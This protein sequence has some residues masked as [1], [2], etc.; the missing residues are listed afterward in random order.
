MDEEL[1]SFVLR[2][3]NEQNEELLSEAT[4]RI[5]EIKDSENAFQIVVENL[6]NP[7]F[8][9]QQRNCCLLILLSYNV[10][11]ADP[12]CLFPLLLGQTDEFFS[13]LSKFIAKN[14]T[15]E[16]KIDEQ[17]CEIEELSL[18]K[19][20]YIL[21]DIYLN[22]N[23]SE[24]EIESPLVLSKLIQ[25]SSQESEDINSKIIAAKL[26]SQ[27]SGE[28][29]EELV[30]FLTAFL[31][32]DVE[33]EELIPLFCFL[34]EKLCDVPSFDGQ[35]ELFINLIEKISNYS[36]LESKIAKEVASFLAIFQ[37]DVFENSHEEYDEEKLLNSLLS[38]SIISNEQYEELSQDI[39]SFLMFYD[40][41]T[42]LRYVCLQMIL[43]FEE[44]RQNA[45]SIIQQRWGTDPN[46]QDMCY[47]I[48][49]NIIGS[50]D[51][52]FEIDIIEPFDN[53]FCR[54][55]YVCTLMANRSDCNDLIE[56]LLS[57]EDNFVEPLYIAN[58][59]LVSDEKYHHFLPLCVSRIISFINPEDDFSFD[60]LLS[61]MNLLISE[62]PSVFTDC[63]EELKT[64]LLTMLE[65]VLGHA[66]LT[67]EICDIFAQ[68]AKNEA[69]HHDLMETLPQIIIDLLNE[70]HFDVSF[71]LIYS[72]FHNMQEMNEISHQI[73]EA[74]NEFIPTLPITN[75]SC[76]EL[77]GIA[78]FFVRCNCLEPFIPW[79]LEA[80]NHE[81]IY[82]TSF[83]YLASIFLSAIRHLNGSEEV[84][85]DIFRALLQRFVG[86]EEIDADEVSEAFF[87]IICNIAIEN[88]IQAITLI[89][90]IGIDQN[91]FFMM[92]YKM[93]LSQTF[94]GWF[95]WKI[96]IVGLLKFKDYQLTIDDDTVPLFYKIFANVCRKGNDI[97]HVLRENGNPYSLNTFVFDPSDLSVSQNQINSLDILTF[98]QTFFP[99]DSLDE[100]RQRIMLSLIEDISK[101]NNLKPDSQ[102]L[103]ESDDEDENE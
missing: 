11:L 100:S 5:A 66:D 3:L 6:L 8:S 64:Q 17:L 21:N 71:G 79:I 53:V 20:I 78:S 34:G 65:T 61:L 63:F 99:F 33:N 42:S 85:C 55:N 57:S 87:C 26:I 89:E 67:N 75:D 18:D 38:L 88:P 54:A 47:Y 1:F 29:T 90:S 28:I 76:Y 86:N 96:F 44:H 103:Q 25:Q 37:N 24:L 12:A 43:L 4:Q 32:F 58:S 80:L 72:L 82:N 13:S 50:Y 102:A 94:K 91:Q 98:I 22:Y 23:D 48:L 31:Q 40:D 2:A 41:D 73:Y 9:N 16:N 45:V 36:P 83:Q 14:T 74:L 93:L 62:N 56:E 97:F 10:R 46:T 69:F 70:D 30:G 39:S 60:S 49:Q 19:L 7:E 27:Y 52:S 81:D 92:A 35:L 77:T 51:S 101:L 68:L 84:I 95:D 59:V 15:K